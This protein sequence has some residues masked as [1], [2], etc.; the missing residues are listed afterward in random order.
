MILSFCPEIAFP[1]HKSP[2]SAPR[3]LTTRTRYNH[4]SPS[5]TRLN[6]EV[7]A[8]S[9]DSDESDDDF[10]ELMSRRITAG[11]EVAM[12]SVA[13]PKAASKVGNVP[14]VK[15][16]DLENRIRRPIPSQT[17]IGFPPHKQIAGMFVEDG[18]GM[19]PEEKDTEIAD[20]RARK[21]QENSLT[22]QQ[23]IAAKYEKAHA[24][25]QHIRSLKAELDTTHGI[26]RMKPTSLQVKSRTGAQQPTNDKRAQETGTQQKAIGIVKE[27]R[28]SSVSPGN[29]TA[30]GRALVAVE[31]TQSHCDEPVVP[32][33]R[34]QNPSKE[35][36]IF[37]T[38]T[39]VGELEA[40]RRRYA[41]MVSTSEV[42]ASQ[43]ATTLS[44]SL[45]FANTVPLKR[46]HKPPKKRTCTEQKRVT[47]DDTLVG[48]QSKDRNEVRSIVCE[49]QS[50][51]S[52]ENKIHHVK[53]KK[54]AYTAP[55]GSIPTTH[56]QGERPRSPKKI[57]IYEEPEHVILNHTLVDQQ[58]MGCKDAEQQRHG[59]ETLG[60]SDDIGCHRMVE[61]I[62]AGDKA[63][64]RRAKEHEAVEQRADEAKPSKPSEKADIS[65]KHKIIIAEATQ[66]DK[67][68]LAVGEREDER[69]VPET[70]ERI[71]S[72]SEPLINSELTED[73]PHGQEEG[74]TVDESEGHESDDS[75]TEVSHSHL[76]TGTLEEQRKRLTKKSVTKRKKYSVNAETYWEYRVIRN[77][78]RDDSDPPLQ[79]HCGT[80][81]DRGSA[82]RAAREEVFPPGASDPSYDEYH[83]EKDAFDMDLYSAQSARG[84]ILVFTQ[85]V[86]RYKAEAKAVN[87]DSKETWLSPKVYVIWEKYVE[88]E[89]PKPDDDDL[90]GEKPNEPEIK[91]ITSIMVGIHTTRHFANKAASDHSIERLRR[92]AI[93]NGHTNIQNE[94]AIIELE[95]QSREHLKTLEEEKD[96]YNSE[97]E[98]MG[99]NNE[100]SVW[101]DV[102]DLIGPRN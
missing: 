78:W 83:K 99:T 3:D 36:P 97:I 71:D 17:S 33:V 43:R 5:P 45:G 14:V 93:K 73:H 28:G 72:H 23:R 59:R 84:H 91:S 29:S 6:A 95:M 81:F 44:K 76:G 55:A 18:M 31:E 21:L 101:V 63:I 100:L 50:L 2:V 41:A 34:S 88:Y 86:L 12:E 42:A 7:I 13:F 30:S 40:T 87:N 16:D 1:H 75:V 10:E 65:Q 26:S 92:I 19:L 47:F 82:N 48:H 52:P 80:Y 22:L 94:V 15:S 27:G 60:I 8:I 77:T 32:F 24:Q 98:V 58:P 67:K 56:Q 102:V 90:F 37:I 66:E 20:L 49:P 79:H 35:S 89:E 9:S 62:V 11:A 25:E 69:E 39:N 46:A 4:S 57:N 53:P 96:L 64:D 54:D 68:S 70:T 85:R 61:D 51:Q 74:R 38:E